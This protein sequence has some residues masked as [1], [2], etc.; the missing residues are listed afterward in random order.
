MS[1]PGDLPGSSAYPGVGSPASSA[2]HPASV[3][4]PGTNVYPAAVK[5]SVTATVDLISSSS[6]GASSSPSGAA[7][8]TSSSLLAA[9][10]PT[11]VRA[12][13]VATSV[14]RAASTLLSGSAGFVSVSVLAV[15]AG[16]G[17]SRAADAQ[18][19]SFSVLTASAAATPMFVPSRVAPTFDMTLVDSVF[20]VVSLVELLVPGQPAVRLPVT[21]GVVDMDA[22]ATIR[23]RLSGLRVADPSMVPTEDDDLLQPTQ[24]EIRVY[25]GLK[26]WDGR[27]ELHALGVF[28]IHETAIDEVNGVPQIVVSGYDR[29]A[30][31][32]DNRWVAPYNVTAGTDAAVAIRSLITDRFGPSAEF[33]FPSSVGYALPNLLFGASSQNNPWKDAQEMATAAAHELV[34]TGDGKFHL[35][36]I[37]NPDT[38]PPLWRL[39]DGQGGTLTGINRRLT[40]ERSYTRVIARQE[41]TGLAAP[42]QADVSVPSSRPRPY[43]YRATGVTSQAQLDAVAQA[44]LE[45]NKG[46]FSTVSF[47][48]IPDPRIDVGTV[49]EVRRAGIGVVGKHVL[50]TLRVPIGVTG[51]AMSGSLRGRSDL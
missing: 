39:Y 32:R 24:N 46:S 6:F 23:R 12:T 27:E 28:G 19:H 8:L 50:E 26:F 7:Q 48:A 13:L 51:G 41:A 43:F 47:E 10:L 25:R 30:A 33:L 45:R 14:L 3:L 21:E 34:V 38:Q 15:G 35:R 9:R 11:T 5:Q 1:W 44:L 40:R 18:M 22:G 4:Y 49:G 2:I 17:A 36:P 31:V 16:Q 20:E 29:S 42:L 37:A